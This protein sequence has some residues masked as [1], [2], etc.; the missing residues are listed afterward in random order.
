[1]NVTALEL[2]ARHGSVAAALRE[3]RALLEGGPPTDLVLL[4]EAALTGYLDR[5]GVSALAAFAEPLGGETCA[6]LSALA[7][8]FEV[9][10]VGPLIEREADR[11]YNSMVGFGPDGAQVLHYRKR[12]PWYPE[13]WATPGPLPP[14]L[15]ELDGRR[16]TVAICFDLHFL[17]GESP[18]VL[19]AAD[20]LLF[21]SAWVDE[22]AAPDARLT[23]L[24]ALARQ[25]EVAIVNANWGPGVVTVPGQGGSMILDATGAVRIRARG[26]RRIDARLE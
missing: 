17:E 22:P 21:P 16:V 1:M 11:V 23:L 9:H 6:Q 25:F 5:Q 19:R 3:V 7:R 10:L 20:L 13:L 15:I 18:E 8:R 24:P 2:P 12:H 14:P 4:P 26:E